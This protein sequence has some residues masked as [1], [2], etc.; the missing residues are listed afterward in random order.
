M[1]KISLAP[2]NIWNICLSN[3]YIVYKILRRQLL[4]VPNWVCRTPF[5]GTHQLS[6]CIQ[7]GLFILLLGTSCKPHSFV[8]RVVLNV[9]LSLKRLLLGCF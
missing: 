8:F 3:F 5:R 1:R 9:N 6:F 2:C 7:W 4:F